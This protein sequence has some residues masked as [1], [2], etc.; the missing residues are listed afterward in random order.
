ME[1]DGPYLGFTESESLEGCVWVGGA[2]SRNMS[3]N[4]IF[5]RFWYTRQ[6][7]GEINS[8]HYN[9][10]LGHLFT[11]CLC[12]FLYPNYLS[13]GKYLGR[14]EQGSGTNLFIFQR[15]LPYSSWLHRRCLSI[16]Y[17]CL[18]ISTEGFLKLII[19]QLGEGNYI[20]IP[21]NQPVHNLGFKNVGNRNIRSAIKG[22]KRN[23][24]INV[25]CR[26]VYRDTEFWRLVGESSK[27]HFFLQSFIIYRMVYLHSFV[28][29]LPQ[30]D[31][32]WHSSVGN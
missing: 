19:T 30:A 6:E 9:C 18:F 10:N 2:V 7:P 20:K 11:S 1:T 24:W 15:I 22:Q 23:K 21:T 28:T 27:K 25:T 5:K 13:L 26:S 17:R 12:P 8:S 32:W 14:Y 31:N 3:F 29:Y 16:D 4:K